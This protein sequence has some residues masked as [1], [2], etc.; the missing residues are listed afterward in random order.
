M[1]QVGIVQNTDY[2]MEVLIDIKTKKGSQRFEDLLKQVH[3]SQLINFDYKFLITTADSM[4]G[5]NGK[6]SIHLKM[7][8][9]NQRNERESVYAELSLDQFYQF[10]HEMK[11]AYALMEVM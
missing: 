3:Y 5:N 2:V 8:L 6:C 10:F 11:R 1:A 4:I 9:L 7:D